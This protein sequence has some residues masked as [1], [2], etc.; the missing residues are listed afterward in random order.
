MVAPPY[1]PEI[2]TLVL[3]DTV[4][5]LTLKVALVLPADTVTLDGTVATDVLLLESV[6]TA[7]PE[8]AL[9]LSVTVPV[10]LLPPLTLVGF[11]VSEE[12][13]TVDADVMVREACA[14]LDPR[15]AVITAVVVVVTVCVL[16]VNLALVAPAATVTLPGTLAAELLLDKLTTVPPD[17]AAALK[18]TVP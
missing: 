5:V 9:E 2:A 8:G 12:R 18:V 16:T 15:V 10:E 17:G 1:V 6:T 13:L 11:R 4:L 14:E 7:P 3:L